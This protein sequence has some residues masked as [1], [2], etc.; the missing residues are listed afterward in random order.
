MALSKL[1][2]FLQQQQQQ[3]EDNNL[4]YGSINKTSAIN[5][6]NLKEKKYLF[7]L[8]GRVTTAT[9]KSRFSAAPFHLLVSIF[10]QCINWN[11]NAKEMFLPQADHPLLI[12]FSK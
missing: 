9:R 10:K 6:I 5:Q 7:F 8:R 3:R 1:A 4:D 12:T 11:K 2:D